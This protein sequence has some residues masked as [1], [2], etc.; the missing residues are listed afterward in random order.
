MTTP[1]FALLGQKDEPTDAVDEYC[2]YLAA[3]LKSH[4]IHMEIRRVPWELHG[5][6]E[7]LHALRLQ[8]ASWRKT[9]IFVQYTALAWSARGF[10]SRFRRVLNVLKDAGA[11]IGVVFHDV[12]PFPGVRLIDHLR[13][14]AQL[15]A[16]RHALKLSDSAIFTV[17]PEQVSWLGEPPQNAIF[18]PVG[19]NLPFP[20]TQAPRPSNE[21]PAVGVFS[22]TGGEQGARETEDILIAVRRASREVGRMR[23]SVFGRHAELRDGDLRQGLRD[24][25]VE[26]V[27]E[28]V[29][30][31]ERI[32]NRLCA[33][34][35]LLFVRKGI[36]TRRSSGIAGIAA[37]LPVVAYKNS[38]TSVPITEA[39][40]V[41]VEESQAD[42]A[43]EALAQIL[44]DSALRGDL[45]ARSRLVY[46][47]HFSWTAIGERYAVLM[48][49]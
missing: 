43:G 16:M 29:A 40:V 30:D 4:A 33:C 37:G 5:W 20:E 23:L 22:I 3:A 49:R 17:P 46:R 12:E 11:R 44:R 15:R 21:I 7:S 34:D 24:L 9:W 47:N 28:G 32:V 36:S 38:E 31:A 1:V 27:V 14:R 8:A 18:I 45:A 13:R 48:N 6:S 42:K 10:P 2:R 35:V 41:L 39:G 19:A 26:I 25:P